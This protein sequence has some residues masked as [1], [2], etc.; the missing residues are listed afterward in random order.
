VKILTEHDIQNIIR[1]ELSKL[2]WITFRVNVGKVK[3]E[4]GRYFD[5]GLPVGFSDL[6]AFKDG[7]TIF[8]EVKKPGGRPSKNQLNFKKQMENNGFKAIIAYS[9]EDVKNMI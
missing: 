8:I 2:G 6:I 7:Q 1:L 4:D 9:F 3:M 5:T